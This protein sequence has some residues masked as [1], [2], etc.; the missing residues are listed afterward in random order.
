MNRDM[1]S[2]VMWEGNTEKR[3]LGNEALIISDHAALPE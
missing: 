3:S 1:L 2:E